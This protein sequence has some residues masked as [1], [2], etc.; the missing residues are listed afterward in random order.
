MQRAS[1]SLAWTP[2]KM[3]APF[4]RSQADDHQRWR[5]RAG[6]RTRCEPAAT[7]GA[8]ECGAAKLN[9]KT[10]QFN[11]RFHSPGRSAAYKSAQTAI[12]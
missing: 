11:A 4:Q 2:I 8:L 5:S 10:L 6:A 12:K 1:R 3:A 7:S 9:C